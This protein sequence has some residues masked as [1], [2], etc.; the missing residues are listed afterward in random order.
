M[1]YPFTTHTF[2]NANAVGKS[3]PTLEAVRNA[4]SSASWTTSYLNMINNIYLL[5]KKIYKRS[6]RR[7]NLY[8]FIYILISSLVLND[9]ILFKNFVLRGNARVLPKIVA[10]LGD[11]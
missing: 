6:V 7:F 11:I 2:T 10:A 8:N 4:Y 3:G 5:V 9:I 1:L